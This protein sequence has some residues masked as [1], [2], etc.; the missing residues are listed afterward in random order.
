MPSILRASMDLSQ[1][2]ACDAEEARQIKAGMRI[3]AFALAALLG[4][5]LLAGLSLV[6]YDKDADATAQRVQDHIDRYGIEVR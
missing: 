6:A 1:M 2:P 5:C 3:V 4:L